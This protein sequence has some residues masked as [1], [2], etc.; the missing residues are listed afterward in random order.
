MTRP[1]RVRTFLDP[2]RPVRLAWSV[3]SSQVEGAALVARCRTERFEPNLEWLTGTHAEMAWEAP[4]RP[5]EAT[6]RLEAWSDDIL[7]IG[8]T[9]GGRLLPVETLLIAGDPPG[10]SSCEVTEQTDAARPGDG[11][12][13]RSIDTRPP[14]PGGRG[15]GREAGRRHARP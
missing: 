3:T 13:S 14:S 6:L 8:Y 7:R 1:D 12:A 10:P 15:C 5:G 11:H 4:S 9:P 2:P